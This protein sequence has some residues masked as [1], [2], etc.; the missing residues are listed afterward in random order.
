MFTWTF[1]LF[2][3]YEQRNLNFE[4]SNTKQTHGEDRRLT[5]ASVH[6]QKL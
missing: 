4:E 3:G 1:T 6:Q 5:A 2:K